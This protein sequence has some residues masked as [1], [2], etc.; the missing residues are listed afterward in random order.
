M[1]RM[2]LRLQV[3]FKDHGSYPPE[4]GGLALTLVNGL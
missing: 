1:S 4:P 3:R 2:P